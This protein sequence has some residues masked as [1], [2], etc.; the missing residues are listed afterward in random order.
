MGYALDVGGSWTGDLLIVDTEEL[1]T[2]PP[3]EIH[4]KSKGVDIQN[5]RDIEL[6]F[7]CKTGEILQEGQLLSSAVYEA[8]GDLR[9]ESQRQ[10]SEE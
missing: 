4:E 3:F 9:Q 10:S 7:T 8:G 2:M 5:K 6:V 1:K